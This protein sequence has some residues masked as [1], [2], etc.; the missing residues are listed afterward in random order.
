M[1][2]RNFWRDRRVLI[3]GH[4]GFKGA[5][6]CVFL[7]MLG[8]RVHGISR[9]VPTQPNLFELANIAAICH[10]EFEDIRNLDKLRA[11]MRAAAPEIVIHC[12]AQSLVRESYRVPLE[13]FETNAVGTANVLQAISA[14]PSVRA[15]VVLTTDKCYENPGTFKRFKEEDRLGGSDPYSASK[16]CAEIVT[17]AMR[18]SFFSPSRH[19][20]H[21]VAIATVRAGNVIGGGDWAKDRLVPDIMRALIGGQAP[22]IRNPEMVRPW[23]H[24]LDPIHGYLML[25]ERLWSNGPS[26]GGAWNF[27]PDEGNEWPVRKIVSRVCELWGA[28]AS[29]NH[30]PVDDSARESAFLAL[31]SHRSRSELGWKPCMD[32]DLA[33]QATTAW[34]RRYGEGKARALTERQIEE[35]LP[36]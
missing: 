8:A 11:L 4:T 19:A 15:A 13:T 6:L 20:S 29:W 31:D 3:T 28:G 5:W 22:Q 17:H 27:G 24:V 1:P 23:Q 30:V 35:H 36:L 12:A 7:R 25:A 16:A 2:T 32:I 26:F 14:V 21:R 34:Y 18:E 9:D 10:S 33:L